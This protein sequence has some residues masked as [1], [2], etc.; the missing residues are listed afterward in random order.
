MRILTQS[1]LSMIFNLCYILSF[2]QLAAASSLKP[3][4][5]PLVVRNP[6]LS[7]WLP[8]ARDAPWKRWPMF[9]TGQD[10]SVLDY[11]VMHHSV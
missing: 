11:L 7:A 2:M 5:L 4:V 9:W 8:D 3:P 10:V 1:L 6:Y